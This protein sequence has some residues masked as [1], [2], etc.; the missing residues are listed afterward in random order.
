MTSR[1]GTIDGFFYKNANNGAT[2]GDGSVDPA[3]RLGGTRVND[4]HHDGPKLCAYVSPDPSEED[5]QWL[6]QMGV[7]HCFTWI[8]YLEGWNTRS[9]ASLRRIIEAHGLILNNIGC[10]ELGKNPAIILGTRDRDAEIERFATFI[11]MLS[12]AG[13]HVTTFTW[14]PEGVVYSTGTA[15]VRGGALGRYVD[16]HT[17]SR[18]P[19]SSPAGETITEARLW[20]NMAYFLERMVPVCE[21]H[22]VRL[23]LHPNDP[24]MQQVCGMPCLMRTR[25]A[26]ERVFAA[27]GNSPWVGMEFCCGTWMEG[28]RKGSSRDDDDAGC[29]D[30]VRGGDG[31]TRGDGS[32]S[33]SVSRCGGGDA[34]RHGDPVGVD[35]GAQGWA[36]HGRS[37]DR[38]DGGG[39]CDAA[40]RVLG[41]FGHGPD[42]LFEA[43]DHFIRLG[44]VGI[45]HLRN[46]TAPL[47][48]F[49]ETFVDDGFLDVCRVARVLVNAK[50]HGTVILDHTPPFAGQAG[51]RCA[52]S[53]SIGY[54]K[55]CLRAAQAAL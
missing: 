8:R 21:R 35:D 26:F 32:D 39:G 31:E 24:P 17:L 2:G 4:L 34:S 1:G 40:V 28:L 42:A 22:R 49:A 33:K 30:R 27:A 15:V 48:R 13:V 55:A 51:D 45:V 9:I 38:D 47:P 36:S 6:T 11:G 46:T 54:I 14:E 7:T 52:T 41:G 19:T 50:F 23:L 12:K 20:A 29:G 18:L 43:L 37:G 3:P 5:L 25:E 16:A 44:K 53:F 10:L